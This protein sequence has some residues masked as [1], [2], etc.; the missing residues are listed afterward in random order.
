METWLE[1]SVAFPGRAFTD[2]IQ[3]YRTDALA[4]GELVL[5]G[6]SIDLR[7]VRCPIFNVIAD[8]DYITPAPSSL[9]LETLTS[10]ISQKTVRVPGGHIGL[11]TGR[12]A[13]ER[14][15]PVVS[16][17]LRE[18]DAPAQQAVP[19]HDANA[20]KAAKIPAAK[21]PL[22][23]RKVARPQPRKKKGKR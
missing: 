20:Q 18:H 19:R 11:S 22:A 15:W 14:L 4:R 16:D 1:D 2:W 7:R 5:D 23:A 13:H 9:A 17:W 6:V 10:T 3:L 21:I 8:T 12:G